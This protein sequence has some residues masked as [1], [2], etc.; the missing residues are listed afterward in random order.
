MKMLA[1][2]QPSSLHHPSPLMPPTMLSSPLLSP[3]LL[4][5]YRQ[6]GAGAMHNLLHRVALYSPSPRKATIEVVLQSVRFV[7][8]PA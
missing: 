6:V 8:V 5:V 2:W 1:R 4:S 3:N 7:A